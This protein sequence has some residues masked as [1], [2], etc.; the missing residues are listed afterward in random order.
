MYSWAKSVFASKS[1]ALAFVTLAEGMMAFSTT[2]WLALGML[3][4]LIA[5]NAIANGCGL[6]VRHVAYQA[7]QGEVR[8]TAV[9]KRGRPRKV[10]APT[11]TMVR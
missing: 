10:Q 4:L 6:A 3:C 11:L 9:P 1:K 5:I 8:V 7:E 2:S